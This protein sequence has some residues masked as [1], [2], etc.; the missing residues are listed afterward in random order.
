MGVPGRRADPRPCGR[1]RQASGPDLPTA[2]CPHG[3]A[4]WRR[5][6]PVRGGR[7]RV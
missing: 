5:A 1:Q 3:Q 7:A 4:A 6:P 2:D